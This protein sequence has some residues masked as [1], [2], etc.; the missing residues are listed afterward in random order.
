MAVRRK[1]RAF[2]RALFAGGRVCLAGALL[3]LAALAGGAWSLPGWRCWR[4][5]ACPCVHGR[6]RLFGSLALVLVLFIGWRLWPAPGRYA[7]PPVSYPCRRT[8]PTPP[9]LP[10]EG[11]PIAAA[12]P[13]SRHRRTARRKRPRPAA[14]GIYRASLVSW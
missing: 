12:P 2:G 14:E 8:R 9:R 13:D 7:P 6:A 3:V 4:P 1:S 5:A 11:L 10:G